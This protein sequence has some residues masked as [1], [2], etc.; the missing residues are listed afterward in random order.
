MASTSAKTA[1]LH[2]MGTAAGW[3]AAPCRSSTT[4]APSERASWERA[5]ARAPLPITA[6]LFLSRGLPPPPPRAEKAQKML[7]PL[8]AAPPLAASPL[9]ASP[10]AASP[11][12]AAVLAA[13]PLSS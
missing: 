9:A 8:A 5:R 1:A 12:A 10:L 6:S 4:V 2:V 7:A 13:R 11:L 3:L